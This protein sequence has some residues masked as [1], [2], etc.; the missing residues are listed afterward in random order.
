MDVIKEFFG[1]IS[2]R[3]RSH[4]IGSIL[5][6]LLA[7][8]W[9]SIL[10]LMMDGNSVWMKIAYIEKHW[11]LELPISVGIL[12]GLLNPWVIVG[13]AYLAKIPSEKLHFLQDETKHKRAMQL[14][15]NEAIE[16]DKKA[17]L[18][19]SK[20]DALK[21]ID[22]EDIRSRLKQETSLRSDIESKPD[23]ISMLDLLS[24]QEIYRR[25]ESLSKLERAIM[26]R[27]GRRKGILLTIVQ[28]TDASSPIQID[29]QA[30]PRASLDE[31]NISINKLLAFGFIDNKIPHSNKIS[32]YELTDI[33][34]SVFG[35]VP[36]P[37]PD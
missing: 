5:V 9:D 23:K 21:S 25:R 4:F 17:E 28:D 3:L 27:M 33:G 36:T 30:A 32:V 37:P 22:D 35:T 6:S 24:P 2:G 16:N 15:E 14:L 19:K 7:F 26:K 11:Q 20:D 10:F 1:A 12:I 31:Y 8:N 18:A 13:G 29:G 34:R